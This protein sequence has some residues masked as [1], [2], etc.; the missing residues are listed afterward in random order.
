MQI[1]FITISKEIE[2]TMLYLEHASARSSGN[3]IQ[4]KPSQRFTVRP[5]VGADFDLQREFFINLSPADLHGRFL[6]PRLTVSDPLLHFLSRVDQVSHVLLV[7]TVSFRGRERMVGE[8]RLVNDPNIR[9]KAEFAIAVSA[10]AKGT[11]LAGRLLRGLEDQAGTAGQTEIFGDCLWSNK[12]MLG[13]A[14]K[15]GYRV[16]MHP[17]D[18]TLSR[19]TKSLATVQT[20]HR[21]H[22]IG[23]NR[24]AA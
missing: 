14:G 24:I 16:R 17:G 12:A 9:G 19:M 18:S 23:E 22:G 13:L 11:G 7:A 5:Y 1:G 10:R 6:T 2:G 21:E 15:Q 3:P 8:A 20:P 4:S